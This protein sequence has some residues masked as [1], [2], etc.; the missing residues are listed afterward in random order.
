MTSLTLG[1]NANGADVMFSAPHY[2]V[3]GA[4][5]GKLSQCV[6]LLLFQVPSGCALAPDCLMT[7][8][9]PASSRAAHKCPA[10]TASP[11]SLTQLVAAAD[12]PGAPA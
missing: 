1:A 4:I 3:L 11:C 2:S 7:P 8:R 6:S 12:A 10:W 9:L 5:F